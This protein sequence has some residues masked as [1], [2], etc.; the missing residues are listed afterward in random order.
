MFLLASSI[1]TEEGMEV[2]VHAMWQVLSRVPQR[3]PCLCSLCYNLHW[4]TYIGYDLFSC[5]ENDLFPSDAL[6][7][8][9]ISPS[10]T[11]KTKGLVD[12][13]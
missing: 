12:T 1:N 5:K 11:R 10:K 9:E 2:D 4:E 13:S 3:G 7:L 6:D 8:S